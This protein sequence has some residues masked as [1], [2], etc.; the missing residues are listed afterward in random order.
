[1]NIF[2]IYTIF[3]CKKKTEFRLVLLIIYV[4]L[5]YVWNIYNVG[6]IYIYIYQWKTILYEFEFD[7]VK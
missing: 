2:E 7:I 1:M 5:L 6:L 3:K 4:H